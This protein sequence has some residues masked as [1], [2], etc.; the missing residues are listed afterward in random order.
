MGCPRELTNAEQLISNVFENASGICS[1]KGFTLLLL[2]LLL[3][4]LHILL[5]LLLLLLL[6]VSSLSYFLL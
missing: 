1:I 3:H 5:L 4:I 6:R 2:L